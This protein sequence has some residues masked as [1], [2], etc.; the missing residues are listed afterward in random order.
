MLYLWATKFSYEICTVKSFLSQSNFPKYTSQHKVEIPILS[1]SY[2]LSK[3]NVTYALSKSK[4]TKKS[5]KWSISL[6][7]K[8]AKLADFVKTMNGKSVINVKCGTRGDNN[9]F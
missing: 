9:V 6:R 1:K 2:S 8:L 4:R 3:K 5:S 7:Y